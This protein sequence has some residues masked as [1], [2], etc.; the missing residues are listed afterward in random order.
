M[1]LGSQS[2]EV[3]QSRVEKLRSTVYRRKVRI[4]FQ[5]SVSM[6][7]SELRATYF[8]ESR[9][10]HRILQLA[11]SSIPSITC[12]DLLIFFDTSLSI[13]LIQLRLARCS[14]PAYV[15]C[16]AISPS[17]PSAPR[18]VVSFIPNR[19]RKHQLNACKGRQNPCPKPKWSKC[20]CHCA[21]VEL[22]VST[23]SRV[24]VGTLHATP[25]QLT[26]S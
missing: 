4:L 18:G 5:L 14:A 7:V 6:L 23:L 10:T 16:N 12:L 2:L 22:P 21:D 11:S 3:A 13:V 25:V 17:L 9:T 26:S 20:V 24:K 19:A 8:F 15:F 1:L